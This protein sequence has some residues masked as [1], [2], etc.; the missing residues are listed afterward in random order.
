MTRNITL[1]SIVVANLLT[2]RA[3]ATDRFFG[4][5][6]GMSPS[7]RYVVTAK[8]PE[9]QEDGYKA[10]QANF[11]YTFT[12]TRS[13]EVLWTRKQPMGEPIQI[14][15]DPSVT[16]TFPVEGSPVSI[17]VSDSGDT[18][19]CT[20]DDE[21]ILISLTGKET[22][23]IH[24]LRDG[25][26]QDEREKYVSETT[27]GPMWAGRSHWYFVGA[28]SREYFVIR[29]WWGRHVILDLETGKITP[30]FD[31]LEKAIA[32][33]ERAYVIKIL[34]GALDGTIEKCDCCGG[35]HEAAFA[36]YLAGV[37]NIKEVLPA[38]RKLEDDA[39]IGSSTTGGFDEIPEGRV[40]PFNYST[41]RTRQSIH[42]AIRRLGEKPGRFPCTRFKTEHED[43]DQ[44]KPYVRKPVPGSRHANAALIQKGMSPEEV[45]NLVDCPDYIPQRIWQYDMDADD[46]YTLALT[47]SDDYRVEKIEVIR[48]ALWEEGTLR[49]SD[50]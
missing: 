11:L 1:L 46:P 27:I 16:E 13:G 48:P 34:Q 20:A 15:D 41:Y 35:P 42:L 33:A 23:K 29:P 5:E 6:E 18:V 37:L 43:Y 4:D 7:G 45:I 49:D 32:T 44:M 12:D 36:A 28:D 3:E 50:H 2:T 21:L 9:N 10:F 40:S 47:W 22:G 39:S 24:L 8:S 30:S 31:A 14:G 38:L 17:H 19:I 25:F 26:T